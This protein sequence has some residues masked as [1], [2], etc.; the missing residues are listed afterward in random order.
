MSFFKSDKGIIFLLILVFFALLPFFYMK[1]GLLIV[2]TG[3]EYYIPWQITQGQVLYKDIFSNMYGPFA[4]LF[5]AVML[6]I[7]GQKL[8]VL[9]HCGILNSLLI[10]ITLYLLA[11]EFLNK[12]V[13]FLYATVLISALVYTS[14]LFSSNMPYSFSLVYALSSFLLSLLFLIKYSKNGSKY[15]A[16]LSCFFAGLS[17]S[18]KY[19]YILYPFLILWVL[20]F[21]KPLKLK[22]YI[23]A[24]GCF[25]IVPIICILIL[26]AQGVGFNDFIYT[27]EL[28]RNIINAPYLKVFYSNVGVFFDISKIPVLIKKTGILSI[29]A[30]IP[31]L[32]MFLFGFN[33]KKLITEKPILILFIC[34]I[35]SS[36]KSLLYMNINNTG[37]FLFP[38]CFLM[39]LILLKKLNIK[40][41]Y[42]FLIIC[43]FIFTYN[44]FKNVKNKNYK[45]KT[46]KGTIY[47]YPQEGII[48]KYAIKF[49]KNNTKPT[50]SIV[51]L[52]EG[53]II[54]YITNRKGNNLYYNLNPLIYYDVFGENKIISDFKKNLPEYFIIVPLSNKTYGRDFFLKDYAENFQKDVISEYDLIKNKNDVK[55]YKRK[56]LT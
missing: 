45:L 21:V 43:I 1:Q 30:I 8:N 47:S 19:E 56:N 10:I 49:V 51:V 55:I 48:V 6:Y 40:I 11:R 50:D 18:S 9:Y 27:L 22:D 7:F 14:F 36:A 31:L 46:E 2:D 15:Y 52:P 25:F 4:Y 20:L 41:L 26:L 32:N 16:Y 29:F 33:F 34:F 53:C 37:I 24:A 3:R 17:I 12:V 39:L 38:V 54:N 28:T 35:L 42:L 5:N 23:I 13:S 44:D